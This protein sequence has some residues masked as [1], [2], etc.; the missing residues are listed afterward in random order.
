LPRNSSFFS[1]IGDIAE[2]G[3]VLGQW[4]A[5]GLEPGRS[6]RAEIAGQESKKPQFPAAFEWSE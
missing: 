6:S 3:I 5:G 4:E 2:A 1:H